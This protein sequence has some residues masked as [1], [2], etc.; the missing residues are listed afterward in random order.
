[1]LKIKHVFAREILNAKG[2]PTVE[3]TVFLEDGQNGTA[4]S[5]SG[6]SVGKYEAVD[7]KDNDP[8]RFGGLGVLKALENVNN[9]IA[10]KL[11]GQNSNQQQV[12][13]L[14]IE[15]DGTMSKSKLGANAILSVSMA[16]AKAAAKSEGIPLYKY[17]HG[18]LHQKNL[19]LKIPTPA[20]NLINGGKHADGGLNFQE[21]LLIP[22]TSKSFNDSLL[23][24]DTVYATLRKLIESNNGTTLVGDEGGFSPRLPTNY[25]AIELMKTAVGNTKYR[26]NY[27]LFFGMDLASG[28]FYFDGKYHIKDKQS[29]LDTDELLE[30]YKNLNN[31]F[32][33]LYLEDPFSEDDISGWKKITK[34]CPKLM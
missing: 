15:L 8:G 23:M 19:T 2:N 27:D 18:Y 11:I 20:F 21:F 30:Y 32:H 4:S 12:D 16:T 6:T 7:L 3:A 33:F 14:M 25:A 34:A 1:M 24:A 9:V 5:P 10:P 31:E 29:P 17:L 28:S 26:Y 13:K 22:A